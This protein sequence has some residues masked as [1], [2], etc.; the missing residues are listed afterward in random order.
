MTKDVP[1]DDLERMDSVKAMEP[2]L[3]EAKSKVIPSIAISSSK[4]L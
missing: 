3:L 2:T 4:S 1:W